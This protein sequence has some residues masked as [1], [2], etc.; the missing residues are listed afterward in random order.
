[1]IVGVCKLGL[2]FRG[3]QSLKEK[4]QML[5]KIKD[6]TASRFHVTIAEVGDNDLW[7][8]TELG[9]AIVGNGSVDVAALVDKVLRFIEEIEPHEVLH[10]EKEILCF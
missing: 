6:R 9:F 8:R 10:C 5:R 4:R 1:M 7:Q 2:R 3:V